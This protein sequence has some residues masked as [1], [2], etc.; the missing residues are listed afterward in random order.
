LRDPKDALELYRQLRTADVMIGSG[1]PAQAESLLWRV[2]EA[3]STNLQAILYLGVL[4]RNVGRVQEAAQVLERG[5][6]LHG[7]YY[8]FQLQAGICLRRLGRLPEAR[9]RYERA[10]ELFDRDGS[11]YTNLGILEEQ[12]GRTEEA[13]AAYSR[14]LELTPNDALAHFNLGMLQ[15]REGGAP[16]HALGHI[17]RALELDPELKRRPN[18]DTILTALRRVT[19]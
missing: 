11:L 5:C 1:V 12:S 4:L 8:E 19:R 3:D 14:A 15:V 17:E 7:E 9:R 6:S 18:V 16:S 13:T 2:L 10:I